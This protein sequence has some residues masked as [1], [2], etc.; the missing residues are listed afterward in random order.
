[1]YALDVYRKKEFVGLKQRRQECVQFYAHHVVTGQNTRSM[2]SRLFLFRY[3][4]PSELCL[5]PYLMHGTYRTCCLS[6]GL[7]TEQFNDSYR[8]L[9]ILTLY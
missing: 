7:D 1:M 9:F 5:M 6:T 4:T 8:R 3:F 2:T